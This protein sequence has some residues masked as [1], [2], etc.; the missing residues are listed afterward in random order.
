MNNNKSPHYKTKTKYIY[1]PVPS[2]RLGRS[3]GID[4]VPYKICDYDCIYCQ[5][6]KTKNKTVERKEYIPAADILRDL[7]AYLKNID[8]P[9]DYISISGSGEPTLNSCIEEVVAKIKEIS[10][11]PVTII[12]NGSF[13]HL[14]DVRRACSRADIVLPSLD[15]GDA[16]MFQH[17]NR[18]YKDIDYDVMVEG[19]VKFR[20]EY[21]GKIW[22][23]VFLLGGVNSLKPDILN[24]RKQIDKIKP[25]KV[26]VNT[27]ARPPAEDYAFAVDRSQ[28]M[29]CC[30]L[31]GKNAEVIADFARVVYND[32]YKSTREDILELI[33][34]RPCS[35]ED[36]AGGLNM[37][38][39]EAIKYLDTL[40]SYGA[41]TELRH[42]GKV[43]YMSKKER[44]MKF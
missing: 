31:F 23:E 2:R 34:R 16:S 11:I 12:T 1:G 18:P 17:V 4:L 14:R 39:N 30:K 40:I 26:Q 44:G 28:L 29:E 33:S 8:S 10:K 32:Q 20:E 3:L 43:F 22:L 19:L 37:Q 9:P 41:I 21:H 5:L 7:Q 13:L 36:I 35:I 27:V 24:I 38:P 6:G 15:A 42:S 25:D